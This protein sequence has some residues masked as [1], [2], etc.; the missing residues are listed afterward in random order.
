MATLAQKGGDPKKVLL[1]FIVGIVAFSGLMSFCN[2]LVPG[3][4]KAP[5]TPVRPAPKMS[6]GM[7]FKGTHFELRNEGTEAWQDITIEV[8]DGYK[9]SLAALEAGQSASIGAMEFA[10]KQGL[11][12]N[13]YQM[14]PQQVYIRATMRGQSV[15]YGGKWPN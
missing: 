10:N 13:P 14:K 7:S 12:F 9:T 2:G 3:G 1:I 6:V 5:S 11:R 8:N 4:S 15:S